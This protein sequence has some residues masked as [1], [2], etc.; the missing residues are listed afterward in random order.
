MRAEN[1]LKNLNSIVK[2][3]D[4]LTEL[5]ISTNGVPPLIQTLALEDPVTATALVLSS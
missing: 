3:Y 4:T 5:S 2:L 1:I